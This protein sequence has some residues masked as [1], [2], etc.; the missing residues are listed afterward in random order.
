MAC[1]KVVADFMG[2]GPVRGV[3]RGALLLY[4]ET[5]VC[6]FCQAAN[7]R[8]YPHMTAVANSRNITYPEEQTP[9]T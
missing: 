3:L 1:T 8:I 7:Y 4:Y 9:W 5:T 2:K 6:A